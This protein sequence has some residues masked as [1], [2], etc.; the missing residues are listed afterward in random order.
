MNRIRFPLAYTN[1]VWPGYMADPYV[2]RWQGEYFA[3]GTGE[4]TDGRHF[5]LL[6]SSDLCHWELVSGALETPEGCSPDGHYWAPAVAERDGKFYLYYSTGSS[7]D[8]T[9]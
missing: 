6:R 9:V 3:Y 4:R 1:P 8:D 5:P 2:L 7:T